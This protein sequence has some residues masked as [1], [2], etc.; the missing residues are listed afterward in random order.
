MGT[1][2]HDKG[3]LH[4][5]TVAVDTTGEQVFIGKCDVMDE[6]KVVL[7]NLD[8]RTAGEEGRSKEEHIRQAAKMGFWKKEDRRV[9]P[10]DQ[11]VSVRPLSEYS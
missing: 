7:E 3:P 8:V 4:G 6:E 1:F 11:V 9:I 2:H 10:A 5:I